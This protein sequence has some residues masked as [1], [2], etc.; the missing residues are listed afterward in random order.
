MSEIQ[1]T[2]M[3][4]RGRSCPVCLGIMLLPFLI[5]QGAE[6]S[7]G[8]PEPEQPDTSKQE[9]QSLGGPDVD[10]DTRPATSILQ[11]VK[12]ASVAIAEQVQD[13]AA[14]VRDTVSG[15]SY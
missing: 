9:V 5:L 15:S 10:A 12:Q 14:D 7:Q 11:H 8:R 13:T 2:C 3:E 6:Q 4:K 1:A